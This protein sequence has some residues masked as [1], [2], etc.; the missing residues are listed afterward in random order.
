MFGTLNEFHYAIIYKM[1]NK[2]QVNK[3]HQNM[4]L[5]GNVITFCWDRCASQNQPSSYSSELFNG[6]FFLLVVTFERKANSS[7][8]A[9][10]QPSIQQLARLSVWTLDQLK[11]SH[12]SKRTFCFLLIHIR[13]H[14]C[15]LKHILINTN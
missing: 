15:K 12:S 14:I 4:N 2:Q 10:M 13:K 7:E 6:F 11:L 1:L 8:F 5:V 3:V 9:V